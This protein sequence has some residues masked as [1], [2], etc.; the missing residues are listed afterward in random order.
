MNQRRKFLLG[1]VSVLL[2]LLLLELVSRLALWAMKYPFWQPSR[3]F[4]PAL[5]K[6]LQAPIAPNDTTLN[7]LILGGSAVSLDYGANIHHELDSL[8]NLPP[9][10]RK[11]RL[12]NA[13]T[14]AH[15]SLDNLNKYKQLSDKHFDLVI[16]YEAINE[17]RANNIPPQDFLENYQHVLWYFDMAIIQRHPEVNWF[18]LPFL[19]DKIVSFVSAKIQGKQFMDL[20]Q[21]NPDFVKYG[22]NIKTAKAFHNNLEKLILETQKRK[23]QLLLMTYALYV[24]PSVI[25]NGG[26]TDYRDF[27]PC[28][29]PSPLHL[30]GDPI[31]VQKGVNQHN[32]QLR[33]LAAQ[34]HVPLLDMDQ[35]MPRRKDAYCDLCHY[36]HSG[37]KTFAQLVHQYIVEQKVLEK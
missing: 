32:Q 9:R 25:G 22:A 15:T 29:A 19:I 23:E 3:K 14:P 37:G 34:Y 33:K 6:I 5:E 18:T 27:A 24:P 1:S 35:A 21:I 16:Y 20:G 11:V 30:W 10:T 7:V 8:L 28:T 13:A 2:L 17:N 31:N 12:F 36:T 26:Y 4:Y